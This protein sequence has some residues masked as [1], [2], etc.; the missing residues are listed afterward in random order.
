VGRRDPIEGLAEGVPEFVEGAESFAAEAG[1]HL[2]EG[3]FDRIEVGT[4]RREVEGPDVVLGQEIPDGDHFVGGEVVHDN[5]VT[6]FQFGDQ[7]LAE[8]SEEVGSGQGAVDHHRSAEPG[9]PQAAE[10]GGGGPAAFGHGIDDALADRSPTVEPGHRRG[11]EGLVEE[12]EPTR[13]DPGPDDVPLRPLEID[14][15]PFPFGRLK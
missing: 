3:L 9:Q 13:I 15:R 8:V 6:G 1:F 2:R 11:A 14:V 5:E 10:E 7:D 12:D 4:V